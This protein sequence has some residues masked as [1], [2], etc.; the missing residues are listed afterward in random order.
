[1]TA[2]QMLGV[3][4]DHRPPQTKCFRPQ[5]T[6]DQTLKVLNDHRPPQTNVLGPK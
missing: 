2:D 6:T 3:L 4:N 5:M 1:M